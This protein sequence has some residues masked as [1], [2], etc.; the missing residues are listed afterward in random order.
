MKLE[1]TE[2]KDEFSNGRVIIRLLQFKDGSKED[3]G[4]FFT[5]C[6]TYYWGY[7]KNGAEATFDFI[8]KQY[9]E[10]D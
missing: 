10:S 1:N 5:K 2:I 7:S 8:V 9:R 3:W 6:K 4:I